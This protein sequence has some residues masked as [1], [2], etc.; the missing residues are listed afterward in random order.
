MTTNKHT[1][2]PWDFEYGVSLR[3]A[4]AIEGPN[5]ALVWRL[6]GP[7][8][9]AAVSAGEITDEATEANAALIMAAP[10]LLEACK[11]AVTCA[12][13]PDAV[14]DRLRAA[15]AKATNESA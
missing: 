3:T 1:K 14:L 6:D 13:L 15:I 2:G 12:S 8:Q 4:W 7:A 9:I 10:E 5:N 11:K